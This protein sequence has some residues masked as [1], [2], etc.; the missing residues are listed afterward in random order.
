MG[1]DAATLAERLSSELTSTPPLHRA[2]RLGVELVDHPD[3][4]AGV[5]HLADGDII[6]PTVDGWQV[7]GERRTGRA[8]RSGQM[9]RIHQP[10]IDPAAWIDETATVDPLA[11]IEAGARIAPRCTIGADAHVGR[12]AIVAAGTRI[13][14]GAWVGMDAR[15]GQRSCIGE[16]AVV[17]TGADIGACVSIG[18]GAEIPQG[19]RAA[20]HTTVGAHHARAGQVAN[21]MQHF[22]HLVERLVALDRG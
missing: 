13:E 1:T 6:G 21:R 2:A 17:G 3:A 12:G 7:T 19:R 4:A 15:I 16:G 8:V 18:A 14:D 9:D 20:T 5:Y 10:G 22:T 11:R